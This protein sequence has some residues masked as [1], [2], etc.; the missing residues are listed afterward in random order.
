MLNRTKGRLRPAAE[1]EKKKSMFVEKVS[2]LLTGSRV[3]VW[4]I[5]SIIALMKTLGK[6]KA[7]DG[8]IAGFSKSG[9]MPGVGC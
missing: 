7:Y 9:T 8:K 3:T 4:N 5:V 1:N 6:N 2:A